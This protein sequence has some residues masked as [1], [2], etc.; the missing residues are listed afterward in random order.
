M[1]EYREK[2]WASP[3]PFLASALLMPASILVFA[4]ISMLWGIII[5]VVLYGAAVLTLL[6][7]APVVS[8]K[9]GV[10]T[11][12]RA[13]IGTE[14]IGEAVPFEAA[15]AT[16]ERGRRLDARAWLLIRGWIR[17]VVRVPIEDPQ[18]PAPYWLVST[19]H[20]TTLAAAI[21]GSRRPA[22]SN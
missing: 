1:P 14:L 12:G 15:E 21:N 3:A 22:S 9:D 10:F 4:P 11:A 6:L 18:D 16:L 7:T 2:L 20:P 5:A 8:V 13:R 17:P 19:R